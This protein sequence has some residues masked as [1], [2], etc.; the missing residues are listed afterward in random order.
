MHP[1]FLFS[2]ASEASGRQCDNSHRSW[3]IAEIDQV[4][5][6][7]DV[8]T[9]VEQYYLEYEIASGARYFVVFDDENDRDGFHISLDMYKAQLGPVT[10]EV[11]HRIRE[12]FRGTVIGPR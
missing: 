12:K 9:T 2:A 5:A 1:A 10:E 6:G 4:R 11:F 3:R 7:L 8:R